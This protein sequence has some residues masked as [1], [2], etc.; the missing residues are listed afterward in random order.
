M[1]GL[2]REILVIRIREPSSKTSSV[3]PNLNAICRNLN[4][5]ALRTH[6]LRLLGRKT[7]L[8]KDFEIFLSPRISK[9]AQS[10]ILMPSVL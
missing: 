8:S 10:G 5:E 4:P 1:S 6:I 3:E 2:S 9:T 7:I